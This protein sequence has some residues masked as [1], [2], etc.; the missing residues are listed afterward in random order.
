MPYCP[1]Q[2]NQYRA[3]RTDDPTEDV[4]PRSPAVTLLRQLFPNQPAAVLRV[5]CAEKLID[6]YRKNS[7][8]IKTYEIISRTQ[9]AEREKLLTVRWPLVRQDNIKSRMNCLGL[10]HFP[11][12]ITVSTPSASS[13]RKL[14]GFYDHLQRYRKR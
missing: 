10:V 13:P 14:I 8:S 4:K 11:H 6:T 7:C 1:R 3:S 5:S 12:S 2:P 9:F